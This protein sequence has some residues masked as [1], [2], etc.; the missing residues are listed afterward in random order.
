MSVNFRQPVQFEPIS[1]LM[2]YGI[3]LRLNR[4]EIFNFLRKTKNLNS[5]VVQFCM[6]QNNCTFV[7][8]SNLADPAGFLYP[9]LG[10]QT[11]EGN[12][13]DDD[14]VHLGTK[15]ISTFC[16]NI[17]KQIVKIRSVNNVNPSNNSHDQL[18]HCTCLI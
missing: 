3:V 18:I 12:P 9:H 1:I 17:K 11:R 14:A 8:N 5:L 7:D 2:N 16:M 4:L 6:S 15:G 10:P 13:K